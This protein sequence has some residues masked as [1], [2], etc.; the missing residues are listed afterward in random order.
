[1][2]P[3]GYNIKELIDVDIK[4]NLAAYPRVRQD[5]GKP[6]PIIDFRRVPNLVYFFNV[7]A[8]P[9]QTKLF[10]ATERT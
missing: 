1:M 3:A 8:L 5:G 2:K 6:D 10:R 9:L 7:M 4:A